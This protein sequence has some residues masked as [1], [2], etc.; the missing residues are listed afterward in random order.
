L[1][2]IVIFTGTSMG[3]Q[4]KN[5][6]HGSVCDF[7][8]DQNRQDSCEA[9]CDR[10]SV[11]DRMPNGSHDECMSSC[12]DA[13]DRAPHKTADACLCVEKASCQEISEHRCPGAPIVGG[14]GGSA[15]GWSGGGGWNASGGWGGSGGF[16][17]SGGSSGATG[18]S[19]GTPQTGGEAGSANGSGGS[20]GGASG[21]T[22]SGGNVASDD[23]GAGSGGISTGDGGLVPC[24]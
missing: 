22:G 16:T 3:C 14:E 17:G 11:C 15:G 19:G 7:D 12:F 21:Q 1:A 20:S 10:L 13:Y 4:I 5:C 6:E 8:D 18:G 24:N 9:L 23:A 2:S